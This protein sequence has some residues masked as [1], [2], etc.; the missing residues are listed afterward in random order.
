MGRH[1]SWVGWPVAKLTVK[2]VESVLRRV[3]AGEGVD[4]WHP[5]GGGMSLRV[6]K[7]GHAT[8]V[9]R[10][11]GFPPVTLGPVE[12]GLA[13]ARDLAAE[14]IVQ[15]ARGIDPNA[16]KR[17]ARAARTASAAA[18]EHA[19][20]AVVDVF[21]ER[22]CKPKL[23][24]WK[25]VARAIGRDATPRWGALPISEITRPMV[26]ELIDS[27]VDRGSPRQAAI[28]QSYLHRLFKWSVGRGYLTVNPI[29]EMEHPP[30]NRPRDR[31]LTDDE[32]RMVWQASER[33]PADVWPD[34]RAHEAEKAKDVF[35]QIREVCLGMHKRIAVL[36]AQR[37]W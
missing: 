23:R 3:R 1:S 24:T 18:P 11:S 16:T 27:I 4:E 20:A 35:D 12:M 22:Y 34:V 31:V 30:G 14:A 32:L 26:A 7:N 37:G 21:I 6:R 36:E 29:A 13:H 25:E 9:L 8:F 15:Q 5:D 19:F 33:V 17:A 2:Y 28:L 10:R